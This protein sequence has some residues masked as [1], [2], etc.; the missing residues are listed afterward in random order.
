ML[1]GSG[2]QEERPTKL[3]GRGGGEGLARQE[4]VHPSPRED[5]GGSGPEG[6]PGGSGRRAGGPVRR[7]PSRGRG[8]SDAPAEGPGSVPR[9]RSHT[10]LE[11]P[12]SPGSAPAPRCFLARPAGR[13]GDLRRP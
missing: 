6:G 13:A 11:D 5:G 12:A 7:H 4:A 3:T 1:R 10:H 2:T 8:G 9:L